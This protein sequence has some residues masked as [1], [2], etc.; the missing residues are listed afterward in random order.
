M[1]HAAI[2]GWPVG[3]SRSPLIHGYWLRRYGIDGDYGRCEV[4][5]ETAEHFFACFGDSGLIGANVTLPYKE[6][7]ARLADHREEIV[8]RV[9]AAN[10]LWLEDGRLCA[11]NT[12]VAGFIANLDERAPGWAAQ[13]G[14]ALVLGAGGAAAAVVDGLVGRGFDVEL[15]NRTLSRAEALAVRYGPRV[16][17]H[18][19]TEANRY[20]GDASLVVNTTSLGMKGEG[21]IDFDLAR[22]APES[23]VTDIVYVP[24]ETAFLAAARARGLRT[25]DGLGMLLHQAVAGFERWFGVRPEVTEALRA[26]IEADL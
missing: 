10:T 3:H 26:L 4:R 16:R 22:L 18:P 12:D 13:P 8:E 14:R 11:T 9:G 19:I 20:A 5:P 15:F 7:V 21:A 24:L 2:I 1:K 17:P 6:L 23:I 25:V